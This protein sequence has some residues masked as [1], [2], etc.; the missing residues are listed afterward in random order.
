MLPGG[1]GGP[2]SGWFRGIGVFPDQIWDRPKGE[3]LVRHR[4]ACITLL[5]IG[6]LMLAACSSN[7]NNSSGGGGGA[8]KSPY[9]VGFTA[10]LT[11]PI[12]LYGEQ[13]LNIDKGYFD[14]VNSHGGV[15]GHPLKI[16]SLDS[17]GDPAKDA[18]NTLQLITEDNAMMITGLIVDDNCT[19]AA[20]IA[21]AHNVPMVCGI[22]TSKQVQTVQPYLYSINPVSSSQA[23][24][25]LQFIQTL[26]PSQTPKIAITVQNTIGTV[27]FMNDAAS[28]AR[29]KGW[30]VVDTEVAPLTAVDMTTEAAKMTAAHPQVVTFDISSALQLSL[31][32]AMRSDGYTGY[33]VG[34]GQDFDYQTIK[35]LNDPKFYSL[36]GTAIVDP[37]NPTSSAQQTYI[38]AMKTQGLTT[39]A[40][41]DRQTQIQD[42]EGAVGM[43]QGLKACGSTC[44]GGMALSNALDTVNLSLPG[45]TTTYKWTGSG[46][47]HNPYVTYNA[48]KWN[49]ST[50]NLQQVASDLLPGS[51]SS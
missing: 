32:H 22:S 14:Y 47:G 16:V 41:L 15:N 6:G 27:E 2:G 18:S 19:S 4:K 9:V 40:Q 5:A 26:F 30:D 1:I 17:G 8:N 44:A 31:V 43:V 13:Q 3:R 51:V 42:Y 23:N 39:E 28:G 11:G 35:T 37:S 36:N 21:A 50:N 7:S 45:I 34:P 20:P 29:S 25:I 12:A 10:G 49:S 33:F 24:P 38:A 48:Y 46:D